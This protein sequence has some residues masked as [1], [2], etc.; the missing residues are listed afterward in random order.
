MRP[1]QLVLVDVGGTTTRIGV[2]RNHRVIKIQR[3][4][5]PRAYEAGITQI[6]LV[7]NTLIDER[8]NGAVVMGVPGRILGKGKQLGYSPNLP[9]WQ[10][11]R[12][13]DDLGKRVGGEVSLHNDAALGGLGEAVYGAGRRYRIIA[14]VTIGTGIGGV[15]IV[16][17]KIN[18][19]AWG[20][21]PG[22]QLIGWPT[23]R[24]TTLEALASGTAFRRRFNV[25]PKTS[26]DRR[27]WKEE[28]KILG[29]GLTN[30][31]LLWSPEVIILGGSM[32]NSWDLFFKPMM[33]FMRKHLDSVPSIVRGKLKDNATLYGG[34]AWAIQNRI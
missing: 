23:G 20:F 7:I 24:V 13:G 28:A 16:D 22:H 25:D 3:F 26:F 19:S 10:G 27:L 33:T 12:V 1:K 11:R 30:I 8:G 15:R 6:A 17:Q 9:F 5:T 18:E 31:A 4:P 21:E 14:F 2:G 29:Q 34:L 32:T